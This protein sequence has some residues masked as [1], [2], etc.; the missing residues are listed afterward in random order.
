MRSFQ[1]NFEI[2]KR[3]FI[4]AFL[5][6]MTLLLTEDHKITKTKILRKNRR[7][8]TRQM[9]PQKCSLPQQKGG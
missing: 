3:S 6:F 5:I 4:G 9:L 2:F 7:S 1:D 8:P